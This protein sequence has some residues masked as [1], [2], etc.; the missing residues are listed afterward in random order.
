M[1]LEQSIN[2]EERGGGG[3]RASNGHGRRVR[4]GMAD[5]PPR[6]ICSL[7]CVNVHG[8]RRG[9]RPA[10]SPFEAAKWDIRLSEVCR[11][12]YI[13]GFNAWHIDITYIIHA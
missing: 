11:Y 2:D 6:R 8:H 7:R 13:M 4:L 3:G 1:S 12:A 10:R 5:P 9:P